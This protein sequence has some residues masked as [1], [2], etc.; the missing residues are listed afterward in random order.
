MRCGIYVCIRGRKLVAFVPFVNR[1]YRNNWDGKPPMDLPF[2][3][4]LTNRR[5]CDF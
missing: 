4:R 3:R 2:A 1:E 5:T